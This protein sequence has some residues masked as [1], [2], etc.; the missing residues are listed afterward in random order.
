MIDPAPLHGN[1]STDLFKARTAENLTST[2]YMLYIHK[3]IVVDF[4]RTLF[5]K[6]GSDQPQC[7]LLDQP[8]K[9]ERKI[10]AVE[11]NIGIQTADCIVI[12][13]FYPSVPSFEGVNLAC[14]MPL[15]S[16]WHTDQFYPWVMDC[17]SAYDFVGGIRRTVA[18]DDPLDGSNRLSHDRFQ[19]QFDELTFVAGG[20]DQ[21]VLWEWLHSL[22]TDYEEKALLC[23]EAS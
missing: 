3:A 5:L 21:N 2:G 8:A 13:I 6:W 12:G 9:E 14:K 15:T 20:S 22:V 7:R 17:I 4:A 16:L 10:V 1:I 18:Y 11:G 23:G 19:S